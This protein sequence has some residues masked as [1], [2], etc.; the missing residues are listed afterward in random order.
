MTNFFIHTQAVDWDDR[1]RTVK[2]IDV[3]GRTTTRDEGLSSGGQ[4]ATSEVGRE[5][6][7][8]KKVYETEAEPAHTGIEDSARTLSLGVSVQVDYAAFECPVS[9]IHFKDTLMFQTRIYR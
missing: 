2:W 9:T 8:K 4:K 7:T 6:A 5:R 3:N 1:M